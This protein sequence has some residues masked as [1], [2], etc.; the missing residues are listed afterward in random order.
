MFHASRWG[1]VLHAGYALLAAA[2]AAGA[3]WAWRLRC[4]GYGCVGVGIVWMAWAALLFAPV[5]LLGLVLA[6]KR[7][8]RG[9]LA[10]ATRGLLGAQVALGLGLLAWWALQRWH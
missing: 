1:R 4:E 8:P 5:L 10:R 6:L 2:V 9:R 7:G 3:L